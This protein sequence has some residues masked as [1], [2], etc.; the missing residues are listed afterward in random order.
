M[1]KKEDITAHQQCE[2]LKARCFQEEAHIFLKVPAY[3]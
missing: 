3:S 2:F 1:K